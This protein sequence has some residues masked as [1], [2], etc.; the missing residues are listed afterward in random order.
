MTTPLHEDA[1]V[2]T[3]LVAGVFD[4]LGRGEDPA[5]DLAQ[6]GRA[7]ELLGGNLE[8]AEQA[9]DR[10]LAEVERM[11]PSDPPPRLRNRALAADVELRKA[12][13]ELVSLDP[14]LVPVSV[15]RMPG[16]FRGM[17][18]EHAAEV[19]RRFPECAPWAEPAAPD[20]EAAAPRPRSL[21]EVYL[22][23]DRLLLVAGTLAYVLGVKIYQVWAAMGS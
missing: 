23:L 12:L 6:V 19:E 21:G 22:G 11:R 17:F 3:P 10:A 9:W 13:E 2:C 16:V 8:R 5:H 18:P 1:L 14:V 15:R 7:L 4:T 20:A